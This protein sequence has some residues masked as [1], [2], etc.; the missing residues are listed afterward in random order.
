MITSHSQRATM[1]NQNVG[2]RVQK[3]Q[4]HQSSVTDWLRP[5]PPHLMQVRGVQTH[6]FLPL[7]PSFQSGKICVN[8]RFFVLFLLVSRF[9]MSVLHPCPPLLFDVRVG[10]VNARPGLRPR[11]CRRRCRRRR[12]RGRCPRRSN[13][14]SGWRPTGSGTPR[15][16]RPTAGC[17]TP[18]WAAARPAPQI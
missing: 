3:W 9:S 11:G 16:T 10:R 7:S 18:C 14:R 15:W 13:R 2:N 12:Q 1:F 6:V 8:L 5:I 17:W 4:S